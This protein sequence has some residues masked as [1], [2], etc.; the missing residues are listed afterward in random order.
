M[1]LNT[2]VFRSGAPARSTRRGLRPVEVSIAAHP[3]DRRADVKRN[4]AG[5]L[6]A[7]REVAG[8]A[9]VEA[10]ASDR[11]LQPLTYCARTPRLARPGHRPPTTPP[12]L[13]G[14]ACP[15]PRGRIVDAPSL[16]TRAFLDIRTAVI[17]TVA[18]SGVSSSR[19]RRHPDGVGVG[20]LPGQSGD[21]ARHGQARAELVGLE[22]GTFS[23]RCPSRRS[24]PEVI[25]VRM[26]APPDPR[27]PFA[28]PAAC[29]G[30]QRRR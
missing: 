14:R 29:A 18:M 26:L 19:S 15:R 16:R 10:V 8:H 24:E 11:E 3:A 25:S 17:S 2:A 7:P 9:L 23:A 27:A 21:L 20:V 6:D 30:L 4:F 28:L 5:V 22:H 13:L 1:K 12:A